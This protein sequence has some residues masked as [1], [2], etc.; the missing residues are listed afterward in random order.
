M[1]EEPFYLLQGSHINLLARMEECM[2][3]RKGTND[4]NKIVTKK[5]LSNSQLLT[6][7]AS[8]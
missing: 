4:H 5:S 6:T 3:N 2:K 7:T 8:C 1:T